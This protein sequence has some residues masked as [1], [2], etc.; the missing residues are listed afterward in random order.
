MTENTGGSKVA[1][2]AR[3]STDEQALSLDGQIRELREHA[4]AEG[5]EVVAEVR[6][7]GEK[8]RTL[9]RPGVDELLD[10][11]A[12]G[13]IRQVWSWAWDRFG[14]YPTPEMLALE[15]QDHGVTLRSLD[16][17][18]EGDDAEDM[19]IIK[20]LFSRREGRT[21]V[22]R[23]ARGRADKALR[24]EVFGGFRARYGFR[25]VTAPNG[26]GREVNVGY[27]VDPEQMVV[28]RRVF[29]MAADG[30]SLHLISRTFE[31]EGVPNPSG[32]PRWSRTTLRNILTDDVFRP[33]SF[34]EARAL[35]PQ[36]VAATLDPGKTYGI[37]W[38]GRKRSRFAS[39]RGKKRAVY[40]TDRAEWT[41]VPVDVS[42]AGLDRATVDR[43][44]E[45]VEGNRAASSAGDR[46]WEFS[47]GILRCASCGRSM[48]AYRRAKRGGG[49]NNYYRCR[50]SSTVDVC[51]NRRSH[52]ADRLEYLATRTFEYC[53]SRGTLLV[54]YDRAVEERHGGRLP[55]VAKR[56][57]ALAEKL[58]ELDT[59]RRGYLKQN[60]RG[61][62][63]DGELDAMLAEL[64]EQR[65]A[66]AAE[67]RASE[68]EAEEARRLAAA[69]DALASYSPVHR[70]WGEDPD[71]VMPEEFLTLAAG[72][73]EIRRAYKRYGA[74]FTVDP[75]GRLTLK[76]ELHLGALQY[77]PTS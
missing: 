12:S 6:D 18:G 72:R 24:G 57:S 53:A 73:E 34:E 42:D 67:L 22:R 37:S 7:R 55:D 20:S 71:A 28:V 43:A 35:V 51:P 56:R 30:A 59:E 33:H 47:G 3:I 74:A 76:M 41:A 31:D 32:G 58:A 38:S 16:D 62:L 4:R 44:R 5:L 50:P 21:R 25:F 60:A 48:H 17:G 49:H 40:E 19:R 46:S 75:D 15:L 8:R 13:A 9:E 70:D 23:S 45:G 68:D 14:E 77:D 2:Y 39:S 54:P 66:V 64:D 26:K 52:P 1:L 69:R 10:L 27:G 63:S 61:V 11:A 65:R 29:A 36:M